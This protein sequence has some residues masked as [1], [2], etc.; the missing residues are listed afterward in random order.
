MPPLDE[1]S[2]AIGELKG[3]FKLM[4]QEIKRQGK[5]I[6]RIDRKLTTM[7]IKMGTVAGTVSLSVTIVVLALSRYLIK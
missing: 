5:Q 1:M 2:T 7:R 3:E 6:E 4:H